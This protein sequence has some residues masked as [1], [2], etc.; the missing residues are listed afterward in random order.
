LRFDRALIAAEMMRLSGGSIEIPFE[1][2]AK[3]EIST[4]P[5]K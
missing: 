2:P 3:P 4:D 1:T 5:S